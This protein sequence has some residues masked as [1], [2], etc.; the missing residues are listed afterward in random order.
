VRLSRG[1][2]AITL[3]GP[4]RRGRETQGSR[5]RHAREKFVMIP[6]MRGYRA[7]ILRRAAS[8][9]D[10]EGITVADATARLRILARK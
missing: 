9:I 10:S 8:L 1:R 4:D 5:V 2:H 3:C 7:M 6:D